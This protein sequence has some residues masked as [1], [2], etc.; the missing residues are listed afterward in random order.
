VYRPDNGGVDVGR[1]WKPRRIFGCV[2]QDCVINKYIDRS[3]P[4]RDLSLEKRAT[5][6]PKTGEIL[7]MRLLLTCASDVHLFLSITA[8]RLNDG[9]FGADRGSGSEQV[10][11][12]TLYLSLKSDQ[13]SPVLTT[14]CGCITL[15][16]S[17]CYDPR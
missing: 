17:G 2:A 14:P 12:G 11:A 8:Q 1:N 9:L 6:N 16:Q 15:P 4:Q 10:A 5:L 3:E 13:W 7:T